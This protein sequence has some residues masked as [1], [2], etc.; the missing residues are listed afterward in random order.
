[1][2]LLLKAVMNLQEYFLKKQ[3]CCLLHKMG[4]HGWVHCHEWHRVW[5]VRQSEITLKYLSI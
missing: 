2:W 5:D 4:L 3:I 1:M